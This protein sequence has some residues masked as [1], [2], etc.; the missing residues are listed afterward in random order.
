MIKQQKERAIIV[1]VIH[2]RQS[3]AQVEEYLDEL[4]LLLDT[5][6]AEVV[7]RIIQERT[8][9]DPAF[10]V[11][12]GMAEILAEK[13]NSLEADLVVF[14]DDLSAAQLRNLEECCDTKIMDRSGII[15]DIFSRRAKSREAKTQVELA[16]LKYYL[17]RLTKMWTHLS[18]QSGGAGIGLRGPGEKQLE[19][20]RRMIRKR[21]TVLS[22]ELEQ[23]AGQRE[24]RR[25]RRKDLFNVALMGY[26]NAGKSTLMNALTASHLYV[27]NQ[28]FATL[29]ATVRKLPHEGKEHIL[30]IDTVGFIRKL[31]HHLVASFKSTLE[32]TKQ[33]DLLLHV[34]D[35]SHPYYQDQVQVI[36]QVIKE[37]AIDD[38]PV[39]T[40]FNKIDRVGDKSFLRELKQ[41]NESAFLVSAQRGIFIDEL[42]KEIINRAQQQ[43]MIAELKIPLAE[44]K[45]LAS[46]YEWAKIL[47]KKYH[48]D[49]VALSIEFAAEYKDD[50][51]RLVGELSNSEKSPSKY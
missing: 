3:R 7:D 43:N 14:D 5:A 49:Y 8:G 44:Q 22:A 51:L 25:H 33:A 23:I 19:V 42:K 18:R 15:L 17:P 26:T 31:P 48:D 1:G 45:A 16:Q 37:L 10:L 50:Y 21:I 12:S 41:H 46:I 36:Q 30:L 20:D 27:E 32:E 34:V 2:S 6:G 4:A 39:I 40:V 11:G 28:L 13:V 9:F 35:C 38:R 47:K 29:D 24:I